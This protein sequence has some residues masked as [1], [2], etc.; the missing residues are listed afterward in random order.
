MKLTALTAQEPSN[1]RG[2]MMLIGW[3]AVGG[4]A[5]SAYVRGCLD[6]RDKVGHSVRRLVFTVCYT[7]NTRAES[8]RIVNGICRSCVSGLRSHLDRDRD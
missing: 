2:I 3:S 8:I 1:Y 4:Q 7:A 6:P 5:Q